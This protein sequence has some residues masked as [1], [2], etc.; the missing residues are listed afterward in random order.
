MPDATLEVADIFR[1]H[2]P[3]YRRAHRLPLH[4][5]RLM[6]AIEACRTPLLGGAVEWC[7][8]CH[9]TH[10]RYRSCRNRHCPKCQGEARLKWLQQRTAELL[11][12]EYFHVVFTLPDPLA[13]IAFYNPE[14]VYAILFRITAETLLTIARDPQHLGAEIGFFC[15]LHTWGQ[16]L[17]HHPHLH[18]VVPGGGLSPD[19]EWISCRPGFFL[20]VRVLSCLFR[21]LFLEALEK[22]H[23]TGELHFFG[24]LESLHDPAA[25]ARYL[26]P[27]RDADWVVYAK[28]PFGGP[29]K[30]LEYLGRYTHRVAISNQRLLSLCD[31]HVSFRWKD[32]RHPQRPKVMT[33]P[34]EEFIRRFLL[35]ALPPGFQR[36]R[37][38]G[39]LANCHRAGKLEFCRQCLA[40][41][42]S[43]LLPPAAQCRQLSAILDGLNLRRCP[44]CGTGTMIRIEV[45]LPCH[46]PVPLRVDTS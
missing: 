15:V 5:H 14:V 12:T 2:G 8:H 37:Y 39:F 28:P 27:L 22:A 17:H 32:Y 34:A 24:E 33:V 35:H 4:Q 11:P 38:Y 31:G 18:C 13:A 42:A 16:N 3:D 46:G 7:D 19:G 40:Q 30:V 36:I 6:Q 43:D 26:D 45:L 1:Q 23:A 20:P 21:R 10:I 25:F 41:P 29:Q 9:F 44:K